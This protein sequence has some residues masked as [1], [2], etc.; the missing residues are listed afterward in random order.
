[1]HYAI[2]ERAQSE[3]QRSKPRILDTCVALATDSP[4]VK[5]HWP[6]FYTGEMLKK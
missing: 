4:V 3:D 2:E 5:K 1:M 6:E